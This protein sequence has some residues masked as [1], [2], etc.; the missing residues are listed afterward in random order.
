[1][2]YIGRVYFYKSHVETK[3]DHLRHGREKSAGSPP[4]LRNVIYHD[5]WKGDQCPDPSF[6]LGLAVAIARTEWTSGKM[7]SV[8]IQ[9]DSSDSEA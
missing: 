3:R 5:G 6:H 2:T 7:G 1:M 8:A 9:L 4:Y